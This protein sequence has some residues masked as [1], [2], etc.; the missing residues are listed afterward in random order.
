[1]VVDVA[2]FS[3]SREEGAELWSC[4]LQLYLPFPDNLSVIIKPRIEL[5]VKSCVKAVSC[6][7]RL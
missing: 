1:M 4:S 6:V 5:K 2:H 7:S 3:P